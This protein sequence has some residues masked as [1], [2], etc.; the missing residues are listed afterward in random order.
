MALTE[1]KF[2][3][4]LEGQITNDLVLEFFERVLSQQ[5]LAN[6]Y[7]FLGA[8]M[9]SEKLLL[10]KELNKILN[11]TTNLAQTKACA[12]CQ[13][14]IWIEEGT[15]PKTPILIEKEAKNIKIEAIKA[16]QEELKQS[17]NYF[18]IVI[19]PEADSM[20]FNKHSANALLKLVEEPFKNTMF[21]I[22]LDFLKLIILRMYF[23]LEL[24]THD[25]L[26]KKN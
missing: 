20:T 26:Q 9:L 19:F 5:K 13:N 21:M 10:A 22:Q 16:L 2:F 25:E 18:R 1:L 4:D 12:K 17:S 6:A 3:E 14:S 23:S 8:N 11:C 24:K 7:L 15:H